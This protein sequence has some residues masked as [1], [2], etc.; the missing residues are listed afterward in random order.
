MTYR[1][2]GGWSHPLRSGT[3]SKL[4]GECIPVLGTEEFFE[5]I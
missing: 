5:L 2:N 1:G 3:L 4:V